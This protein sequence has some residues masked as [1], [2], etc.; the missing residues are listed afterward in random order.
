MTTLPTT[1][2]RETRRHDLLVDYAAVARARGPRATAMTAL[3]QRSVQ[4][5][6]ILSYVAT[7]DQLV[8]PALRDSLRGGERPA[9]DP[10]WAANLAYVVGLQNVEAQDTPDAIA[11]YDEV[12]RE[13]P[14]NPQRLEQRRTYVELLLRHGD[15]PRARGALETMPELRELEDDYLWIDT[16]N[17]AV[18]GTTDRAADWLE[19]VQQRF[20]RHGLEA[21]TL[22]PGAPTPLDA[23]RATPEDVVDGPLV[24]VVMTTYRPDHTLL[25]S[26]RSILGQSWRNLEILLVDDASPE[27]HAD[28]LQRA[29][30]LAGGRLRL[31]RQPVNQG[32]YAARNAALPHV[33]GEFVTGQDSDDWSHPRRLER[34]VRPMLEDGAVT[35]TRSRALTMSEQL[36]NVRP[37]QTPSRANVSSLMYRR[38]VLDVVGGY[39]HSRMG[40]DSEFMER[41]S[42]ATAPTLEVAEPLAVVR[43]VPASLSRG[44]FG[45]KWRHEA[46]RSYVSAY[47]RWHSDADLTRDGHLPREPRPF[48]LPRRFAP[49][50]P[51]HDTYDVVFASEWRRFGGPQKSMVEEIKALRAAGMRV[52]VMQL[53]ATRFISL[54]A[55]RHCRPLQDML[56]RGDVE[57]V[58]LDDDVTARL[59]VVRYPPVLQFLPHVTPRVRAERLIVLANQAPAERDGSDIRY[60]VDDCRAHAEQLFGRTALWVPQ[61]PTVR[62]ALAPL[63]P[64]EELASFDMPGIIDVEEWWTERESWRSD[65]PV[66]GRHSRDDPMKWP[67]DQ[68]TVR[69]VYPTDGSVDV[70]V[71][72]GGES[73][74]SVLGDVPRSWVV[75]PHNY[76]DVRTFLASLDF[77]VYYQ[78]PQAYDAFGRSTLE[79]IAT[80]CVAVLPPHL[81]ATFGPAAVYASEEEAATRVRELYAD[82][83][84]YRARSTAARAYVDEQFG[85]R[86]YA[87]LVA[88]LLEQDALL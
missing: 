9:L 64:T 75:F 77:F 61:G 84:A 17:P 30:D 81:E 57:E 71:M 46:R 29:V 14:D 40:A 4:M 28:V 82:P 65:R 36:V 20:T 15:A 6:D 63:L 18:C 24:S 66:V 3:R 2:P 35:S 86:R 25:H 73:L 42:D 58:F 37:G 13:L 41:L 50:P 52:G 60:N 54:N 21:P 87:G 5:R 72:G 10:V 8:W 16:L 31:L 67:G 76:M 69:T 27:E 26:V 70:R 11:L 22:S 1:Q 59:L 88:S 83:A 74:V 80:G 85:P 48:P 33:R 43:V 62:G 44:D 39:D 19:L 23:L 78:H 34:Q 51:V 53:A 32:T 38:S 55:G 47:R 7:G 49:T 68:A 56:N 12:L 79:A 45:A